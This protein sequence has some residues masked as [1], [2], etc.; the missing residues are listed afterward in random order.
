M[1]VRV[2]S[3]PVLESNVVHLHS[4]EHAAVAGGVYQLASVGG[5]VW[6]DANANGR[7]DR[8]SDGTGLYDEDVAPGEMLLSLFC[9]P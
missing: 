1:I 3:H 4:G 9:S 6:I 7:W 5:Y 8:E 2:L